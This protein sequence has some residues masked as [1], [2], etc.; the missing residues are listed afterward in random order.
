MP[1]SG[2]PFIW[3]WQLMFNGS[4][5][6][7]TTASYHSVHDVRCFS[8]CAS[9]ISSFCCC[10]YNMPKIWRNVHR[11]VYHPGGHRM[12]YDSFFLNFGEKKENKTR[13]CGL[14]RSYVV[15][16]FRYLPQFNT[17][18][19]CCTSEQRRW[20]IKDVEIQLC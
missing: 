13:C 20:R 11:L 9:R 3:F 7:R 18:I 19:H 16:T 6:H 1:A 4:M 5:H 17:A 14:Y 10:Y 15:F 8:N 12:S 2:V